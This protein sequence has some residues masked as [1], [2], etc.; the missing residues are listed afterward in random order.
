MRTLG[1]KQLALLVD[2]RIG[3]STATVA[4]S[5]NWR[6]R[7]KLW[8]QMQCASNDGENVVFSGVEY[9]ELCVHCR[10]S[11]ADSRT[12]EEVEEAV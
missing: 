5:F 12:V 6:R 8:W 11:L 3:A 1:D 2:L 7:R 10:R 4:K 9:T